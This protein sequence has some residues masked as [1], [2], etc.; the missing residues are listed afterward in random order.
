[1]SSGASISVIFKSFN[2]RSSFSRCLELA[3]VISTGCTVSCVCCEV[4]IATSPGPDFVNC[5][6]SWGSCKSFIFSLFL[7]QNLQ[8]FFWIINSFLPDGTYCRVHPW[9][10]INSPPMMKSIGKSFT[11][12]QS[13]YTTRPP[14]WRR[15][16]AQPIISNI[17]P[18][19]AI[20]FVWPGGSTC[21]WIGNKFQSFSVIKFRHEPES[22][23][24]HTHWF[25]ILTVVQKS[26]RFGL[27]FAPIHKRS[28]D[29]IISSTCSGGGV[30]VPS[31]IT[32]FISSPCAISFSS[33]AA[34]AI[35]VDLL[36]AALLLGGLLVKLLARGGA[37]LLR[38]F[39]LLEFELKLLRGGVGFGK[40]LVELKLDWP[41]GVLGSRTCAGFE[42]WDFT[43]PS[44]PQFKQVTFG[45]I[46]PSLKY[47]GD[48]QAATVCPFPPHLK[49]VIGWPSESISNLELNPPLEG[50]L[51]PPRQPREP[52]R[53]CLR[54][55]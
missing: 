3:W 40:V 50:A 48:G 35:V 15:K 18:F 55:R 21:G 33:I 6:W 9:G 54:P 12:P 42:H 29:K 7:S 22:A 1:M 27:S 24:A 47:P 45:F 8:E 38:E 14:I 44:S 37:E 5:W 30:P 19:P 23:N 34:E 41:E 16:L 52:P 32:I 28:S 39:V 26:D 17:R 11:I 43:C 13:W 25:W 20:T 46:F 53:N 4:S 10:F 31:N 2:T 51:R 36:G 49:Q